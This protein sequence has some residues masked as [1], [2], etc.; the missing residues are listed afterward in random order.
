[1][2]IG[3]SSSN[4]AEG[5]V[6]PASLTFTLANWSTKQTVTVTGVDD[7]VDDGDIGFTIVTA[8]ATSGDV[9]YNGLNPADVSV[10]NQDND[11]AGITVN[12][13]SG[14]VTTEAGE[15][16]TFTIVLASKPT[17]DVIIDLSSSDISE[18]TV[19]PASLTFTP[20]NWLT[21]QTVTVKGVND[22]IVDGNVSYTITTAAAVSSDAKYS[23]MVVA[24]V[25][26]TNQDN[27]IAGITVSLT[28]GLTTTEAGGTA[29]FTVVL[30][31]QPAAN[32][33]IGLSSSN[34]S[35]GTVNPASLTFTPGNW[36]LPQTVTLTGIDDFVDD[37]DIPYTILTAAAVSSDSNF[38]GVNAANVSVTNQDND[39]AGFIVNPT[40]GINTNKSGG[41]VSFT[42]V[43]TSQP[44]ADV[45]IG[46][47]SSDP[48]EGTVSPLSV[49][50]T[51]ANWSTL[52]TVTVTGVDDMMADGA[53]AYQV[54]TAPAA[55]SDL[56][57]NGL[58]PADVSVTNQDNDT[59][60][61]TV[62]PTSGLVT[63]EAGGKATFTIVLNTQ[64]TANVT[65]GLSSS[66]VT[67]GTV[68]PL[69]VTF[70]PANWSAAQTVTVTGSDDQLD[71][72]DQAFMV[73][74]GNASSVDISYSGM[75]VLDVS[76][77]NLN[78]D[79][80]PIA[81]SNSYQ[82]NAK[83]GNPLKIDP[84][85]VLGNDTDANHDAL[86]A[87]LVTNPNKGT[88]TLNSNGSFAYNPNQTFTQV[89]TDSFT[90][91]AN[92]GILNSPAV[93]VDIVIDPIVPTIDWSSPVS[94]GEVYE[95]NDRYV[96]LGADAVDNYGIRQVDFFRWD[97]HQNKYVA[98]G[99]VTTSPFQLILDTQ[100]L[101]YQWNQV[102]VTVTDEAGNSSPL[103]FIWI[104]RNLPIQIFIPV[105]S[106]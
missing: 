10:T 45:T 56:V 73:I 88:L 105:V 92:D 53:I 76:V 33:M 59:A 7:F 77:I 25:S 100:T 4:I 74:T 97:A 32:V 83:P 27:D 90:Y 30:T 68:S 80:T 44:T 70:T 20:A 17:A 62:N 12:P 98:I 40:S 58:N 106:R 86:S 37:G 39:T 75:T 99:V 101:N 49:T 31:S 22:L 8:L 23:G 94:D 26:V 9:K 34:T 89:T 2:T 93:T 6:S 82:T 102:F 61:V 38:S 16:D 15:A 79:F 36:S 81:V 84:P 3:L 65:I 104:F 67:E 64:P 60:G 66:D 41:A 103:P 96:M 47:S 42:I 54:L 43:L 24:D 87:H 13:T 71:D 57:Y 11:A 46:L 51:S 19:L 28:S 1:M 48:G 14:L 5:T 29:S 85:G 21:E 18:G 69:S 55:S 91:R 50:F 72:G 95:V 35:E 78:N 52:Q 63:T